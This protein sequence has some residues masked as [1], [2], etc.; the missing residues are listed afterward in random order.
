MLVGFRRVVARFAAGITRMRRDPWGYRTYGVSPRDKVPLIEFIVRALHTSGCRLLHVPAPDEAPFRFTLE[1]SSGERM[2][3]LVYAF[4]ANHKLTRNRPADEHRFQV[5]YGAKDGKLHE[6]WQDPFHLYTTLF[7]GINPEAGYFVGADPVLHSPTKMFISIELKQANVD[8]I[9]RNGWA[10]W[11]RDR[12][13]GDDRPVEVLVGGRPESFLQYIYFERGA[14]GESQGHRQLLA[15][16]IHG[17]ARPGKLASRHVST[18]SPLAVPMPTPTQIHELTKELQ[19]DTHEVMDLIERA[20]RLKMAVRG[21]VAE[22]HLYRTITKTRGVKSCVRLEKDGEADLEVVF[23]GSSLTVECKNVLRQ[24]T[25]QGLAR[26]DFQRTRASKVDPCSR[27]YRPDEFNI[28]A[29]C[30][31]AVSEAWEFRY[32]LPPKLDKHKRCPERLAS[33]VVVDDR[34]TDD[35]HHILRAAGGGSHALPR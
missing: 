17:A 16:R 10:A 8:E 15:E 23:R 5:K 25:S 30:L 13:S 29:A 33:N 9:L 21:W 22:E 26:V 31:H 4:L 24:T 12:R 6:L 18:G 32:V 1:T 19:L 35:A 14:I 3:V 20:P 7:V 28:L 2:G 34:W 11:E 27:Y